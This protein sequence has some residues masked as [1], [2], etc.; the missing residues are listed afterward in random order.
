L[1]NNSQ[2]FFAETIEGTEVHSIPRK[3]FEEFLQDH[4]VAWK[5]FMKLTTQRLFKAYLNINRNHSF[6]VRKRTAEILCELSEIFGANKFQIKRDD[7]ANYAGTAKETII[8]NL[9]DLKEEGLIEVRGSEIKL[10][11]KK[12]LKEVIN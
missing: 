12:A 3:K 9:S 7:F 2:P 4:P 5:Y 1:R 10:M 6:S 11:N 8:R